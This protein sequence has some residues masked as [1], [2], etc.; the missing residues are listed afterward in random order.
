MGQSRHAKAHPI[1]HMKSGPGNCVQASSPF[2]Q[3]TWCLRQYHYQLHESLSTPGSFR[4]LEQPIACVFE[5]SHPVLECKLW[6][7]VTE[8]PDEVLQARGLCRTKLPS[9]CS[10]LH[11]AL[12]SSRRGTRCAAEARG[13]S[14]GCP[15]APN[16]H[17]TALHSASH[18]VWTRHAPRHW[19]ERAP[20]NPQIER[21]CCISIASRAI[22]Q[23]CY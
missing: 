13:G 5:H 1:G 4:V 15:Y 9:S 17:R 18:S 3:S 23:L 12:P 8:S 2:I 6:F 22:H 20:Q 21:S 16:S 19:T 7:I 14:I 10:I 11:P